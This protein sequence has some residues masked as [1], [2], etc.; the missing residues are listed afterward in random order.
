MTILDFFGE[1]K[2]LISSICMII[3]AISAIV[4]GI[5]QVQSHKRGYTPYCD[6]CCLDY[7]KMASIKIYNNGMGVMTIKLLEI[8]ENTS[9]KSYSDIFSCIPSEISLDYYSVN[10]NERSLAPGAY[11]T[12][13]K[14]EYKNMK[15]YKILR[16]TLKKYT[17]RVFYNDMYSSKLKE[18]KKNLFN[19]YGV[20]HRNTSK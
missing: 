6:I 19:I 11:L 8:I 15:E 10:F 13:F 2:D 7:N 5:L 1:Y 17:L 20:E 14:K 16:N 9:G 18:A 3:T 12:V 4:I